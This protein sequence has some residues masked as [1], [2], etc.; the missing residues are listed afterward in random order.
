MGWLRNADSP[1]GDDEVRAW[2][3]AVIAWIGDTAVLPP[4]VSGPD[5]EA[6]DPAADAVDARPAMPVRLAIVAA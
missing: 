3:R 2:L 5:I 4:R 6:G 1:D